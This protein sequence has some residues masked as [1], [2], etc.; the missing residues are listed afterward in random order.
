MKGRRETAFFFA[1]QLR[2]GTESVATSSLEYAQPNRK[3]CALRLRTNR[4]IV[5]IFSVRCALS[6]QTHRRSCDGGG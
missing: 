5:P 1:D 4:L 6:A 2:S 3:G